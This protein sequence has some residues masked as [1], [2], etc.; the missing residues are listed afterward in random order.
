MHPTGSHARF[1]EVYPSFC[2]ARRWQVV[3]RPAGDLGR[4][5]ALVPKRGLLFIKSLS[6]LAISSI[7]Y[8]LVAIL[9]AI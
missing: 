3:P 2:Y 4:W 1:L 5:K 9:L 7:S 6:I 8:T